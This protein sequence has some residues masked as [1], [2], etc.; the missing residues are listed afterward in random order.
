MR[1]RSTEACRAATD[2]T[3]WRWP[4]RRCCC[5]PWSSG[6]PAAPARP[7]SSRVTAPLSLA[8][9]FAHDPALASWWARSQPAA[10]AAAAVRPQT[11]ERPAGQAG[12]VGVA[13]VERAV[14]GLLGHQPVQGL[15]EARRDDRLGLLVLQHQ[16]RQRGGV[17][18]GG[19]RSGPVAGLVRRRP[20][21]RTRPG[22]SRPCTAA[23]A[24]RSAPRPPAPSWRC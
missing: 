1:P 4:W 11:P 8:A 16:D 6:P 23:R 5:R 3:V 12:G 2:S 20:C 10:L 21:R 18:A 14:G 13:A 22:R 17:D 19:R 24:G 15:G 7:R 9:Y